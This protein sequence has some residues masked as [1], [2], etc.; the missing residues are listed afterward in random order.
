MTIVTTAIAN[1]KKMA[2]SI[3]FFLRECCGKSKVRPCRRRSRPI[4]WSGATPQASGACI[5]RSA[6]KRRSNIILSG[7]REARV[8]WGKRDRVVTG[9]HAIFYTKRTKE[10]YDF[11]KDVLD[12]HYV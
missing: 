12:L 4:P 11:L 10:M 7:A 9:I 1:P 2:R 6:A 5:E 3:I 8:V